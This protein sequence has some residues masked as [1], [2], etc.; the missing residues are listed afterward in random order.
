MT[1]TFDWENGERQIEVSDVHLKAVADLRH[2]WQTC[3]EHISA[4]MARAQAATRDARQTQES[5][6]ESMK[7]LMAEVTGVEGS[8]LVEGGWNCKFSPTAWCWYDIID[9][10][11]RDNCLFCALPSER[12]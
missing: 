5:I 8:H 10:P 9:D 2:R 3:Q 4:V 7:T 6:T 1:T 12:K 11:H